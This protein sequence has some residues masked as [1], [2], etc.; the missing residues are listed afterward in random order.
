MG[1][2]QSK[3]HVAY[4]LLIE[5]GD[6]Q[7]GYPSVAHSKVAYYRQQIVVAYLKNKKITKKSEIRKIGLLCNTRL[8]VLLYYQ[9][10]DLN[11]LSENNITVQLEQ[12]YRLQ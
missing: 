3:S 9:A 7:V 1:A 8:F 2:P 11:C 12:T 10:T 6:Q 4:S 5:N